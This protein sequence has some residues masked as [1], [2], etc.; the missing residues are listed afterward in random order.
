[1]ERIVRRHGCTHRAVRRAFSCVPPSVHVLTHALP[2]VAQILAAHMLACA[3]F[4]VF[5][6]MPGPA[7]PTEEEK[8]Q[9]WMETQYQT[10]DDSRG[11]PEP[12][13]G[14]EIK[15]HKTG[16]WWAVQAA[17]SR[18]RARQTEQEKRDAAG[19]A[20]SAGAARP[21][22]S[23]AKLDLDEAKALWKSLTNTAF[24]TPGSF[25]P[26]QHISYVAG[27]P[28]VVTRDLP[29][30]IQREGGR[31]WG[32]FGIEVLIGV[33][34]LPQSK[35]WVGLGW[36]GLYSVEFCWGGVGALWVVLG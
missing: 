17:I 35:E 6:A 19:T 28:V 27:R 3:L 26:Q 23:E 16:D 13:Y 14:K 36:V 8:S 21:A 9:K 34:L 24:C 5:L 25:E 7:K 18:E 4:F 30:Y 31:G 2:F 12:R 20:S 1:M 10:W 22:F 33:G 15:Q 29:V 11:N 32:K